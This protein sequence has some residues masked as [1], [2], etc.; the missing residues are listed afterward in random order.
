MKLRVEGLPAL[1]PGQQEI[2]QHPARFKVIVAG[3]R[4]GKTRYGVRDITKTGLAAGRGWWIAPSYKLTKPG[5]R[6]L[7]RLALQV[8]YADVRRGS[9]EVFYPGGGEAAVR[10]G[11][12]PDELRA[13]SLDKVVLDEAAF[14]NPS[15]WAEALRPALIDRRGSA[16][17]ISTPKG[18]NSWYYSLV[19]KA[20]GENHKF[21]D[22]GLQG[23]RGDWAVF[24]F[25]SSANPFLP[26]AELEDMR[27]DLGELLYEQEVE[28]RF[29]AHIGTVFKAE[30][31]RYWQKLTLIEEDEES[32][33]EPTEREFYRAGDEL[34][35]ADSCTRFITVDPALS[36]REEADFTV[37]VVWARSPSGRHLVLDVYR[38]RIEAPDVLET[39]AR[40]VDRWAASWVGFES[41]AYQKSLVQFGKRLGLPVRTLTAD[42]DKYSRALTLSARL[43]A[44]DIYWRADAPWTETLEYELLLFRGDMTH[45]HDDQVDALGYGVQGRARRG[46]AAG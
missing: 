2:D 29:L 18:M 26:A 31:F 1:H 41:V 36:T 19:E 32:G 22:P 6:D 23:E 7:R 43:E 25:P 13:E 30:W 45:D 14:M 4:F 9:M 21:R 46:W 35:R 38:D 44:G 3:R 10:T 42:K 28:G 37:M 17:F 16:L 20:V 34:I 12:D 15:V 24:W 5:W 39:A 27:E 40:L 8:P 33:W 11:S